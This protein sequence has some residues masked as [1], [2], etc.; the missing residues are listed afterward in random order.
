MRAKRV[1]DRGAAALGVLALG[2]AAAACGDTQAGEPRPDSA[3]ARV[4]VVSVAVTPA[5]RT[6]FREVIR[7][8]GAVEA[9]NDVIVG[10]EEGGTLLRFHVEKGARVRRGQPIAQIDDRTLRAQVAEAEA[11][12]KL[13]AE[14]FERQR[15]LWEVEKVG[16]EMTYLQAKYE[17]EMAAARL[18]NL[19]ARLDRTTIRAPISGV[20]DDR[21]V[22]A[23]EQVAPGTRVARVVDLARLKVEGG[24]P[25]RFAGTLDV[26]DTAQVTL[27][28]FPGQGAAGVVLYVGAV[29]DEKNRTFPVE[30]EIDNASGRIKPQMIASVEL[31]GET[32]EDVLV[33]PQEA[34][35]RI[36]SGYQVFVAEPRDGGHVA[37]SRAVRLGPS[38]ANRTVILEGLDAGDLVIL[39]GQQQVDPGVRVEIVRGWTPDATAAD[40]VEVSR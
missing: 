27:D 14:R 9:K 19:R 2:W 26:G 40:T 24:V 7:I 32:L 31:P 4:R 30:V 13:A 17:A 10:T 3:G 39:Q 29:V 37:E 34:I 12:A 1:R 15:R 20:L 23:G 33:L 35:L 5:Y 16:S 36:E 18:E 21:Y 38:Y 6:E 28:A 25:E 11:A 22:D 8:V